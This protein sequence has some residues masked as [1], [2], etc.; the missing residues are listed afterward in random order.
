[1]CP[2][3]EQWMLEEMYAGVPGMGA[4]DAWY[5]TAIFIEHAR[6]VRETVTGRAADIS[7]C[8]DQVERVLLTCVLLRAGMP[9]K[10]MDAYHWYHDDFL[11]YNSLAGSIGDPFKRKC[12]IPR[13]CP[14]SRCLSALMPRLW[15]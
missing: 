12:S 9:P 15:V 8:F 3:V 7:K 11:V 10:V 6:I 2:W 13:G 5:A 1:M 4:E 14:C